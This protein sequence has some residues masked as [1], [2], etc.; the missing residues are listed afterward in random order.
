MARV[1]G[2]MFVLSH[3]PR[4]EDGDDDLWSS[5]IAKREE[6]QEESTQAPP[7]RPGCPAPSGYEWRWREKCIFLGIYSVWSRKTLLFFGLAEQGV[8]HSRLTPTM[9]DGTVD[10]PGD[11]LRIPEKLL[12]F[13]AEGILLSSTQR[14]DHMFS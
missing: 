11:V 5:F 9:D 1:R 14:L 13:L 6:G 2:Y 10:R 7:L 3:V 12:L 8:T 4:A